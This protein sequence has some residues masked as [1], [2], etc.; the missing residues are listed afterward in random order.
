MRIALVLPPAKT[1][2]E[3][4]T[5][6]AVPGAEVQV[7]ADPVFHPEATH[8]LRSFAVP[9]LGSPRRWTAALAWLRGTGDLALGDLDAVVSLELFSV[10]TGQAAGLAERLQVPH[11]VYVTE[12]LDDNPLYRLPPWRWY[13]RRI[14][15]TLDGVLCW[16]EAGARHA[17]ARGVDRARIEVV[18]PGVDTAVFHP[19]LS[20]STEPV[21][22]TVGELRADKGVMNVIAA[23]DRAV[24]RLPG[25]FRLVVVGDGPLRD[26]VDAA[27]RARPW[28]EV[29]GRLARSEVA[30][31]LRRAAAFV[32]APESRPFWAEQLGFAVIEA[33]ACGLPV[34]VTR[35]GALGEVV[36]EHNPVV[37]EGDLDAVA[38][39]LVQ[40]LG[41]AGAEWGERNRIAV[42]ERY[43]L[44]TQGRRLGEA[45]ERLTRSR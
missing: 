16:N 38:D 41:P 25:G 5:L 18:S 31:E 2:H 42:D 26:D 40:A 44:S 11:L 28:L 6:R 12:I 22:I 17:V 35:C 20:R 8:P 21:A 33:M 37:D 23:A 14:L 19:P 29:R 45:V 34:I 15:R 43:T 27:A 7:V 32:L 13:S 36:P 10:A 39:G 1:S 30:E 4:D 3:I 9:W 24:A